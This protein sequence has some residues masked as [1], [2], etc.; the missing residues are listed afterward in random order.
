MVAE[1]K[2]RRRKLAHDLSFL[3]PHDPRDRGEEVEGKEMARVITVGTTYV[4]TFPTSLGMINC[5]DVV[6][7]HIIDR[8][9]VG[10][11]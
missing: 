9:T 11:K 8:T 7:V 2:A 5:F 6:C 10:D 4:L 1:P 3:D